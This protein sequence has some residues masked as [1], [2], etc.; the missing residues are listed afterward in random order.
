MKS[1]A[2]VIVIG[3]GLVLDMTMMLMSVLSVAKLS[4][5]N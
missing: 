4:G 3:S 5:G 1:E 2:C